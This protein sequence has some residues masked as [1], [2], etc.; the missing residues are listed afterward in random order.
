MCDFSI[1]SSISATHLHADVSVISCSC[2]QSF[3]C[4]LPPFSLRL[5]FDLPFCPSTS[6]RFS[7]AA[8]SILSP[9]AGEVPEGVGR[10]LSLSHP[11]PSFLSVFVSLEKKNMFVAVLDTV[12]YRVRD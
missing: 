8:L 11:F 9:A 1:V 4:I 10:A 12:F 5:V 2:S 6:S 7:S 3:H